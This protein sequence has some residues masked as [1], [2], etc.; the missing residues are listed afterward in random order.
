MPA[1]LLNSSMDPIFR[2]FWKSLP[3][4][5]LF[6]FYSIIF[7]KLCIFLKC[8][9]YVSG[10]I[11]SY[12]FL[13][14]FILRQY[15]MHHRLWCGREWYWTSD[16]LTSTVNSGTTHICHNAQFMWCWKQTRLWYMVEKYSA[17]W[18]IPSA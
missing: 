12:A 10:P 2:V 1:S 11:M 3:Y 15:A 16:Y 14:L 17:N 18:A 7:L 13:S 4:S 5:N 8:N 6:Q 9:V